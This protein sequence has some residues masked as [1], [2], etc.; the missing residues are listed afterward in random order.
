MISINQIYLQ[1][2]INLLIQIP[3]PK[4]E[5][6]QEQKY[7]Q[8]LII[9]RNPANFLI[10]FSLQNQTNLRIQKSSHK[11]LDFL[12]LMSLPKPEYF[13]LQN[14]SQNLIHFPNQLNFHYLITLQN[15]MHLL[16][17]LSSPILLILV[18][19]KFFQYPIIF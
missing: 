11:Q 9:L 3:L 18:T 17:Q 10:H 2:Q 12:E 4:R 5:I 8:K 19:L 13:Q 6:F 14:I 15:Q 1:I 16:L 7:F